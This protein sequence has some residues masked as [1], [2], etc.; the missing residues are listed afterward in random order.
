MFGKKKMKLAPLYYW[1]EKSYMMVIPPEDEEDILK[2]A[3]N[4]LT[5]ASE[6]KIIENN[7]K[8][9]KN[10]VELKLEYEDVI[11]DVGLYVGGVSIPDYYLNGYLFTD[12]DRE[13][14][15]K[16]TQALTVFMEFKG[17]VK[18]C[19]QFQLKLVNILV[20]N[21]VGVL[22]ESAEKML[23]IE[24]V[25]MVANSKVLPSA[26]NMFSVQAVHEDNGE[27]W[28][29]THGLCRC[30]ITELEILESNVE[31][32]QNHYNLLNTYAMFLIDKDEKF[33]T[34]LGAYIGN[35]IDGSPVVAT[36][37]IWVEGLKEY[38]QK[39]LKMGGSKD[40]KSG[41]N[42][43][44]SIVFLYTSEEN[45]K[46]GKVDKISIY[47]DM[48]GDNPLFFYSDEE[49]TRMKDA[50]IETFDYVKKGFKNKDNEVLIK[51][52]LPLEEKGKF[53][54]IWFELLEIKGNKFKAKLT[55]EPYYFDD[56]HVGY[57]A[58]YSIEDITDWVIY[59]PFYSVN[60]DIA[61]LLDRD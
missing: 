9:E 26:K 2:N 22:D 57:E 39:Q 53:E 24:F 6:I 35:L 42:S 55:Q 54:H 45:E 1:E 10:V 4:G 3:L 21:A 32:Q 17:N 11:Y 46:Q 33:D 23:P 13:K 7:Y 28:L 52:G 25:K 12:S 51:I 38:N 44:T 29:H 43:W 31:N 36:C 18:K 15:H 30:G 19:F 48:W 41:H 61:F 60:S 47:N 37:R 49:T 58:W 34:N 5:K 59:T 8:I 14:I 50:A 27:V 40:R 56:I 16:A 20:P